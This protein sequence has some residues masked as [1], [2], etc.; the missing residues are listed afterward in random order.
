MESDEL[1]DVPRDNPGEITLPE[2]QYQPMDREIS[3]I[4]PWFKNLWVA[5]A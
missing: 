1:P 2:P 4:H 3:F 5:L